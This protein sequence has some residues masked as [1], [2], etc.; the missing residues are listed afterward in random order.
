MLKL[1]ILVFTAVGTIGQVGIIERGLE[2]QRYVI[3]NKQLRARLNQNKIIPLFAF[4]WFSSKWMQRLILQRNIGSTVP[5]INLSVLRKLP[6][7]YPK[8]L[9]IQALIVNLLEGLNEKIE[10]NNRINRE[11]EAMANLIYDYWFVQFEFP[12]EALAKDGIP[13]PYKSSG[14]PDGVQRTAKTR[15]PGRVG[16]WIF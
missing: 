15:N 13:Q 11:L 2:Y 6:I 9:K 5:L 10:L 8:D 16:R 14:G 7:W 1:M 12:S 3:S 4:Y